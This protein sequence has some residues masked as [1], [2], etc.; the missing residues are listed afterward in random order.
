MDFKTYKANFA[1]GEKL[2]AEALRRRGKYRVRNPDY[3]VLLS[4][5]SA[6]PRLCG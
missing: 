6:P 5:G 2:T 3:P 4:S 1:G